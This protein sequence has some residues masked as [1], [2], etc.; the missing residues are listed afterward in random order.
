[1]N[2]KQGALLLAGDVG[3]TIWR[4]AGGKIGGT[5]NV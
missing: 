1:V 5:V 2:E 4:N 3:N